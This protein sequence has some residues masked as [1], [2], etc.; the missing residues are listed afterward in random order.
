M[1]LAYARSLAPD[2]KSVPADNAADGAA[3]ER[4]VD[5]CSRYTPWAARWEIP[6]HHALMLDITGCAHLFGGEAP[7]LADLDKR[8]AAAGIDSRVAIADTAAAAWAWARHGPHGDPIISVGATRKIVS[9]LPPAALRIEGA[10]AVELERLG[11][12]TIGDLIG[13]PR[14]PLA[15]RFGRHIA[16]RIDQLL[17]RSAEPISPKQPAPVW[18][19]RLAFPEP[20]IHRDAVALALDRL[21]AA[22]KVML[23]REHQGARA[24]VLMLYRVDGTA[25]RVEIA[26]GRASRDLRHLAR[27][28]AEKLDTIDA[29]FGIETAL[30]A[31][32]RL[33]RR[34]GDQLDLDGETHAVN[35]SEIIDRLRARLG[36][37]RVS[38]VYPRESHIPERAIATT[39]KK[40]IA[41]PTGIIRPL[42]LLTMPEP[43]EAIAPI[44][45]GPPVAFTWRRAGHRVAHADGPERIEPEWWRADEIAPIHRRPRDYYRV[46]DATGR[47]FWLF[48]EGLYDGAAAPPRWYMH[49]LFG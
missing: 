2:L 44:P 17:G 26:T 45:D 47:R 22:L 31:A 6:D 29:G 46:E 33:E 1:T 37:H 9:P 43:I 27:L 3:L 42:T 13:L 28:F 15:N 49:G 32:T 25:A 20:I 11:L 14:A 7:M 30:L 41:W 4:L 48:R 19:T 40:D 38:R 18:Q 12:R 21:L 35:I 8:L 24:L 34:D 36:P 16:L 23:E 5:W 10:T 39:P